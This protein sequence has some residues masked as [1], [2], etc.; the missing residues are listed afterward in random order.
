MR[1]MSFSQP[2][3]IA[4]A[5]LRLADAPAPHPGPGQ[6]RVRVSVCGVCHTDLHTVEGDLDLPRLPL[7]P[8]HQVV[9][10]VD[11]VGDDSASPVRVGDRVGIPWLHSACRAC[12][13]CS[14][15]TEN[16]CPDARF[17]GLHAHGGY[18]EYLIAEAPFVLPLPDG[19]SDLQAAP[20]L[21][22]GI[23]GYRSLRLADVAPGERVGLFG[24]GASAHLALQIALHWRCEVFVF[25]RAAAHRHHAAELGAKWVGG[26][27]D[28]APALLDRAVIFAPAGP[29]VP[30][31]LE[32]VRPGGTVAI[33]AIHMTP[34]PE[35]PYRL[36][37][38]ERTLRS[39]ANATYS[40]G[41]EFLRVA[42]EANVQSTVS[43]YSLEDANRALEDLKYSRINGEAVLT[44]G[45]APRTG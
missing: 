42:A 26:A 24:F 13:Y 20:L 27:E 2:G 44:I 9:G 30:R 45:R 31:A 28:R 21:C 43:T 12:E 19:L 18:A 16:L 1:A 14:R 3:P 29:V 15:G 10:R 37:Y 11:E 36:L 8:G 23:I 34:I 25:T 4:S 35:L 38:G 41:E 40:D 6:V 17:T 32:K 33:N 22:A 5:P 7:I 39:V